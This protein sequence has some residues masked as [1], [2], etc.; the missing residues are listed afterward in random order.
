MQGTTYYKLK[1]YDKAIETNEKI[2]EKRPN[3]SRALNVKAT[4]QTKAGK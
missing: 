3:D 1:K 2:L 4:A